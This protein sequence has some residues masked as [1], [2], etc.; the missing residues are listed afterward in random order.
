MEVWKIVFDSILEIF[1]SISFRHVIYSIPKFS[2]H[3]I[4][5]FIPFHALFLYLLQIIMLHCIRYGR[6]FMPLS[7]PEAGTTNATSICRGWDS[8]WFMLSQFMLHIRILQRCTRSL[9]PDWEFP[10][11][12]KFSGFGSGFRMLKMLYFRIRIFR[13]LYFCMEKRLP[14]EKPLSKMKKCEAAFQ[15][16]Y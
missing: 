8:C 4:P 1:H 5:F 13:M 6:R 12:A 14:S 9:I 7:T 10:D 16:C 2:F 11:F 3:S 15:K